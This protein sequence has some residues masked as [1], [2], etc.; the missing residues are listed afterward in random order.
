MSAVVFA[1]HRMSPADRLRDAGW[2]AF[3]ALVL[4]IPLIGLTTVDAGGRL[5]VAT[6]FGSLAIFIRNNFV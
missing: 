3:V 2:I 1:R 6:R 5:E 4:G